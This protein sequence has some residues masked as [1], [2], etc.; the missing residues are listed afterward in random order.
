MT[1]R[2]ARPRH[3]KLPVSRSGATWSEE[4]RRPRLTNLLGNSRLI[5]IFSVETTAVNRLGCAAGRSQVSRNWI[6]EAVDS[7][8]RVRRRQAVLS[9][10]QFSVGVGL[11]A[12]FG[13]LWSGTSWPVIGAT[14]LALVVEITS[15][16]LRG[17]FRGTWLMVLGLCST[18]SKVDADVS[19]SALGML[20][21]PV[22]V[23]GS[24]ISIAYAAL[25]EERSRF[26]NLVAG[27]TRP[28]AHL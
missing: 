12:G 15:W 18:L 9:S 14:F 16:R 26:A 22:I 10:A 11:G 5:P 1:G 17:N 8:K 6:G 20:R 24:L 23:G 28:S 2:Q 4:S 13:Y 27:R 19:A 25:L 3:P 7:I 21:L